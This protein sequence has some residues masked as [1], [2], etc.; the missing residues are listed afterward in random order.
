MQH[1]IKCP[2]CKEALFINTLEA[3]PQCEFDGTYKD[4]CHWCERE[5]EVACE[6]EK[7]FSFS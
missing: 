3:E 1:E 7:V 2:H 5:Y 6:I 4:T